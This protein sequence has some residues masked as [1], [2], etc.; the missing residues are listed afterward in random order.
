M[1]RREIEPE[2]VIA[3][4]LDARGVRVSTIVRGVVAVFG[5]TH[6][7]APNADVSKAVEADFQRSNLLIRQ[8]PIR[9]EIRD[10][11]SNRLG[12]VGSCFWQNRGRRSV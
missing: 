8:T 6:G 4:V 1:R 12:R 5:I 10:V 2:H 9:G 7:P 3:R 11:G